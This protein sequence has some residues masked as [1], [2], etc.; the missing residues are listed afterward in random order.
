[1][2]KISDDVLSETFI[3]AHAELLPARV[4]VLSGMVVPQRG[5]RPVLSQGVLPR[6]WRKA[7]RLIRRK[8][9]DW[10]ITL[11][12]IQ[13]IRQT[14]ARAVLAEYGPTGVRVREACEITGVP[15]IV[16]FHGYDASMQSVLEEHQTTYPALFK[17]AAAVIAVSRAMEKTLVSLGAPAE[18]VHYNPCGVDCSLFYGANPASAPPVFLAVGRFVAKKAPHLTL[19]AFAEA[20]R[21]CPA[22]RLRM[23]GDGDLL[24]VCRDMARGLGI[25]DAVTF[26]GAQSPA[27]VRDEMRAARA[28]VQHSV[29][30]AGGDSEGTPVGVIEAGASGLPVIATRHAGIPDVV[31][32]GET[33]FLV[34]ERDV[35]AM[36]AQMLRV[37][38]EP[39]LAARLGQAARERITN[40]FSLARSIDRL[41][42]V[43]D[44]SIVEH[45]D[46]KDGM[47]H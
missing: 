24:D 44:S 4:A 27:V 3:R 28:F 39:A 38:N 5:G 25:A 29:E 21:S 46:G 47:R 6:A 37:A 45:S 12:F 42:A 14:G 18:K 19:L 41:W 26:L 20:H 7:A 1:L 15:L 35:P 30:A 2:V 16:H 8:P 9:W 43:I 17:Q 32:D 22:A 31:V 36:A 23:I 11:A 33:G 40:H 34:A 10:E 13:A